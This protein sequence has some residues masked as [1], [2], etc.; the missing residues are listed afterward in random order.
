MAVDAEAIH[1][2]MEQLLEAR[3]IDGDTALLTGLV[4]RGI[5]ASRS[6]I[7]H[8]LEAQR[9]GIRHAYILIDFDKLGLPD[10]ALS[11]VLTTAR[12]L[13]FRGLNITHPFKTQ[14]I[15]FLDTLSPE[16]SAARAVNTVV[17]EPAGTVGHNTDIWGFGESLRQKLADVPRKRVV[18]FGAGGAGAAVAYALCQFGVEELIII[19]AVNARA[20]ALASSL[21]GFNGCRITAG[22]D[23][24]AIQSADGVV[25]TTPVGMS[26]Y[27]GMPF[28]VDMLRPHHW[29][30]DVIY[31]PL[32]TELIRSA[33]AIGCRTMPGIGMAIGQ[34]V[35]AFELFTG[36]AA[37]MQQMTAH[38]E[39]VQA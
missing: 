26:K 21:N 35:R 24:S 30:A 28:D 31:F 12:K 15:P 14:V 20:E 27:P 37:D 4:G 7:M 11:T 13:G 22:A 39:A 5:Q 10:D 25:N 19:D 9:L 34:A 3:H 2:S 18:Q 1:T 8:E 33:S 23:A 17:F 32:E 6:P 36:R 16:A 29:V 38:F